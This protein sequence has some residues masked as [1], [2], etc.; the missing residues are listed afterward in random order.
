MVLVQVCASTG[1]GITLPPD[2]QGP[3]GEKWL[4]AN[5]GSAPAMHTY[6]DETIGASSVCTWTNDLMFLSFWLGQCSRFFKS[7][8]V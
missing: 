7:A 8:H 5:L 6:P 3:N 1:A 2:F 4:S